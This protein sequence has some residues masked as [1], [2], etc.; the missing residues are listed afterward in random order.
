[1][2]PILT[3]WS[4]THDAAV[5]IC[6]TPFCAVQEREA[7]R[8]MMPAPERPERYKTEFEPERCGRSLGKCP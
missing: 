1:M 3:V 4:Q 6:Q 2:S 8:V 5:Q 7:R